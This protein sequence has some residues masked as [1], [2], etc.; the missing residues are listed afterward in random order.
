ML[1]SRPENG[2]ALIMK[3]IDTVGS[4]TWI[5]SVPW[6][7]DSLRP[8]MNWPIDANDRFPSRVMSSPIRR[9]RRTSGQSTPESASDMATASPVIAGDRR[10]ATST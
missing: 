5:R 10:S 4:S 6:L 1:P 9:D 7:F 3:T 2:P 8:D